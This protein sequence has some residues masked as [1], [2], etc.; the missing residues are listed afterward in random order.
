M[1]ERQRGMYLNIHTHNTNERTH[2]Y[3]HHIHHTQYA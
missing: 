2:T 3:V 1:D